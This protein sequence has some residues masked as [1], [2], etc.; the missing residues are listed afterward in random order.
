MIL[1]RLVKLNFTGPWLLLSTK[2]GILYCVQLP[3]TSLTSLAWTVLGPLDYF[4]LGISSHAGLTSWAYHLH[5]W[6]V[7]PKAPSMQIICIS[8]YGK[9]LVCHVPRSVPSVVYRAHGIEASVP[10]ARQITHGTH[11]AHGTG[12]RHKRNCVV[13][14]TAGTQHNS[15]RL[16]AWHG[17][18]LCR[19][20]RPQ[21]H[22][23]IIFF[24]L[25]SFVY[26]FICHWDYIWYLRL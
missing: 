23:T 22:G 16:R 2:T 4:V 12:T 17:E 3:L 1:V 26:Y 9:Q 11:M 21:A 10:C 18:P 19:V 6:P 7:S 24:Y 25:F 13:C 5:I 14:Q 15:H 20:S 8:H